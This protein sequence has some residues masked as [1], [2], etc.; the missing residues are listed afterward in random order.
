MHR[1]YSIGYTEFAIGWLFVESGENAI[2]VMAVSGLLGQSP[3]WSHLATLAI[4]M[5]LPV[6]LIFLLFRHY[7]MRG[8]LLGRIEE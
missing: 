1:L 5:S 7:L 2:L 6:V 8:L 3:A 4:L